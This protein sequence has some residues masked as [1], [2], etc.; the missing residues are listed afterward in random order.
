M[1]KLSRNPLHTA[2]KGALHGH[3][4]PWF[5]SLLVGKIAGLMLR[6][7]LPN[8]QGN[9]LSRF[10]FA[11]PLK[12]P[13]PARHNETEEADLFAVGDPR[14]E[15]LHVGRERQPVTITRFAGSAG[16]WTCSKMR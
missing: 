15:V 9:G 10:D 1:R 8:T 4:E 7:I 11:L 3:R 6:R 14:I 13:A 16:C 5:W 2:D 12:T